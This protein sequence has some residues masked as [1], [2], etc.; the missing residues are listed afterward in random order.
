MRFDIILFEIIK[1]NIFLFFKMF[2][3]WWSSFL[4]LF[5]WKEFYV[6]KDFFGVGYIVLFYLFLNFRFLIIC[7]IIINK[8]SKSDY[9]CLYGIIMYFVMICFMI[10]SINM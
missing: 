5:L 2:I 1:I 9:L 6:V 8:N 3:R 7:K 4:F 10:V